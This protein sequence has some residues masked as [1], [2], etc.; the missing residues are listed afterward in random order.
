MCKHVDDDD[1]ICMKYKDEVCIGDDREEG[2][3]IDKFDVWF[4][5]NIR[6]I[7]KN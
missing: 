7:M 1:E 2:S 5:W 4:F 3:A 6:L